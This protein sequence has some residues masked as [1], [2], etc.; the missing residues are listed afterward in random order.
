LAQI[1]W[2]PVLH[3]QCLLRNSEEFQVKQAKCLEANMK[4]FKWGL[5]LAAKVALRSKE[6]RRI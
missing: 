6:K 1:F 2:V 4:P 5:Y 3:N